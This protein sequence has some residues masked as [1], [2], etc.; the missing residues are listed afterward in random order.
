MTRGGGATVMLGVG[1]PEAVE[2]KLLELSAIQVVGWK[3]GKAQRDVL[4][5][6]DALAKRVREIYLHIDM[7]VLSL[8]VAPGLV[9]PPVEGGVSL[10]DMEEIM[11]AVAGRFRIR[12]ATL[13]T[14]NPDLDR[15]EKTLRAGLRIMEALAEGLTDRHSPSG[16]KYS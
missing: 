6:L 12:A 15:D 4:A 9:M 2:R 5:S 14:Y 1:D 10:L 13:A 3:E 11:I 16:E 7:D 8:E